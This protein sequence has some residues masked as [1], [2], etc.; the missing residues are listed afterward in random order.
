[1]QQNTELVEGATLEADQENQS[2]TPDQLGGDPYLTP[3]SL[4]PKEPFK[5][6]CDTIEEFRELE[7]E[8]GIAARWTVPYSP[9]FAPNWDSRWRWKPEDGLGWPKHGTDVY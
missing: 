7:A 2:L 1:M 6:F 5:G 4:I 9:E 8:V 3:E